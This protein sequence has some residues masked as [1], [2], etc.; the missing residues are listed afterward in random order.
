M[1]S[2]YRIAGPA[3]FFALLTGCAQRHAKS[4]VPPQAL[5]PSRPPW[6][7]AALIPP[8]PPLPPYNDERPIM[9]DTTVPPEPPEPHTEEH[10]RRAARHHAKTP[11]ETAS[12]ETAHPAMPTPPPNP[13]VA[14]GQ[15]S[16]AS[17]IGQL[18]SAAGDSS[19]ADRRAIDDQINSTESALN[20]MHR[21]LTSEEQKTVAQIRTFILKARA[22][23]KTND[24]DGARTLSTKAKLLLDE[25]TK[26]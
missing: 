8:M 7:I 13:E 17:P 25:L 9:L 21:S 22:A 23:L 12:Q 18:S 15:P 2:G 10:P 6:Q 5:A 16:G 20:G 4:A 19:G 26:Q 24:L 3:L 14:Q 11:Q 1:R